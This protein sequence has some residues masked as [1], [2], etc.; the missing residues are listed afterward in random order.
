MA[1]RTPALQQNL[2]SSEKSQHF[3]EEHNIYYSREVAVLK[4]TQKVVHVQRSFYQG[5]WDAELIPMD[6]IHPDTISC[7]MH[8]SKA[9]LDLHSFT[10]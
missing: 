5:N 8:D 7:G 9:Y 6:I 2:Q 10:F 4:V 3:K 1:G